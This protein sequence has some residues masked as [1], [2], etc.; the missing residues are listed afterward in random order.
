MVIIRQ[1]GHPS[2]SATGYYRDTLKDVQVS[3]TRVPFFGTMH[4]T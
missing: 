2:G 4:S 1:I 3:G